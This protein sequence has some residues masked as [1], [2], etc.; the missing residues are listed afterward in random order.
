MGNGKRGTGN[1]K[2]GGRRPENPET[3]LDLYSQAGREFQ[4]RRDVNPVQSK[5]DDI[6]CFTYIAKKR[7]DI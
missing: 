3:E 2:D 7:L 1:G 5:M 4:S 6:K